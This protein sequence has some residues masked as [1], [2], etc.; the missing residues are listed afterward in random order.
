MFHFI[1]TYTGNSFEGLIKNGLWHA[2]DGLKIM[3]K[4][5]Y[6]AQYRFNDFYG[7][8]SALFALLK[9]LDCIFYIDRLQGGIGLPFW[10]DYDN[11]L[12]KKYGEM[13]GD[14][15][16][17][18]QMHEWASNRSSD[19]K[20]IKAA[21]NEFE[22]N[23]P[24]A[25]TAVFWKNAVAK[26]EKGEA[27]IFTEAHTVK[28]WS[29]LRL[30]LTLN[31]FIDDCNELWEKRKSLVNAPLFPADS[32]Y[33]APRLEIAH[34]AKRLMPECGW[35][36][37]DMRI[38]L[39]YTRGMARAAGIPFGIYYECWCAQNDKGL[40]IPYACD[41]Y[42]NE[43][44][45]DE[46]LGEI[47][48]RSKSR[49]EMGGSSRSLQERAWLYAYFCGADALGEEYGVCNTFCNYRDFELSEYGLVKK[50]FL[51]FTQKYPDPGEPFTPFA[52]VLPQ[53]TEMLSINEPDENYL[54]YPVSALGAGFAEKI[55]NVRKTLGF[56]LTDKDCGAKRL[57]S[58]SHVLQNGAYPDVFDII[59]G[60]M[61]E[62]VKRYRY[63]ID[64]TGDAAFASQNAAKTVTVGE[65]PALL[66]NTV[67]VIPD[68]PV[69]YLFNTVPGGYLML[70][71]NENGVNRLDFKG[72]VLLKDAFV[73]TEI[74]PAA[75]ADF[76]AGYLAGSGKLTAENGKFY[77][78]LNAGEWL[79]LSITNNI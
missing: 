67:P 5:Y 65:I 43:W 13:L 2:G 48:E 40:T 61:K 62:A 6:P 79:L 58:E 29:N 55:R 50:K 19:C 39:A 11:G 31:E 69:H 47:N 66:K 53:E 26:A 24:G 18:F 10:Y 41:D 76:G 64:L 27:D 70:I 49:P 63:L 77:A 44:R 73:K 38:Q 59:H 23:N 60:D 20:R 78:Q 68:K 71:L 1:H 37:P 17:G 36:I 4:P 8:N 52:V 25:S 15:F 34:G 7:E 22:K 56:L 12:L 57:G 30:P 75:F 21:L 33:M 46:L 72:D 51:D 28:E 42:R 45:E 35:Q 54:S 9:E 16:W 32:F 14:K 74:T 3:H